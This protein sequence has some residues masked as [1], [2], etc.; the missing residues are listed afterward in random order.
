VSVVLYGS[1]VVGNHVKDRSNLNVLVVLEQITPD[2]LRAAHPVVEKWRA[3]GQPLPLYFTRE[4]MSDASDV[5]PIEFLDMSAAH[6]V[7]YGEDPLA[8]LD[9]PTCNL[10]HQLEYELR[11][12]LI[13]LRELYIPASQSAERLSALM[14]DSIASFALLFKHVL[15]LVGAEGVGATKREV[16]GQLQTAVKVN[17]QPFVAVLEVRENN[18]RLSLDEAT[19]LFAEY[20][21]SL[22]E[23]TE[24]VDSLEVK[25]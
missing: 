14:A 19:R 12:K 7:L 5:F 6:R 3:K 24:I 8:R 23:V 11:G 4:E 10:R 20:L 1:A 2:D 18:R 13:R 17:T 9:V 21:A 22:E 15:R 16:V 25:T